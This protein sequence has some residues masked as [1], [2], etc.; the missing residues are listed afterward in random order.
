MLNR[1]TGAV[2]SRDQITPKTINF[3]PL[4]RFGEECGEIDIFKIFGAIRQ[5]G[6]TAH[7]AEHLAW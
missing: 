4:F 5:A 2:Q 7:P 1:K 3:D 6:G